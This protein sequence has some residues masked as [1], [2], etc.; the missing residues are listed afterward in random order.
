MADIAL[1]NPAFETSFW[2]MEHVLP[3]IRKR[4]SMPVA[5]LALLGALTPPE[6]RVTILDEN[7]GPLDFERLARAEIVGVTGM[8]VQRRR[9]CE[10]LQELRRR[11]AFVVVGGPWASVCEEEFRDL[12]Q[13]VFV[14]EAEETWPRFLRDWAEG[15]PAR[16][17][18]QAERTDMSAVPVP[19]Y[20]L[21][22]M[23]KYLFGSVQFSRGC[24]H[25]CEFC[26][27][28]VTFGRRPRFKT[29][30]QVLA[31]F[32]ALRAQGMEIIFVVD[33]NLAGNKVAVKEVLQAVARW[34]R[35]RGFPFILVAEASL[36]IADDAAL[37][38]RMA[39]ANIQSVFVGIESLN[40]ASLREARKYTNIRRGA[41][42][43]ER[44][45][46]I[47]DAGIEVWCG[48]MLGFDNDDPT[49]FTAQRDFLREA[50]I[51]DAMASMVY[52]IPRTGS[53]VWVSAQ[54]RHALPPLDDGPGHGPAAATRGQ[55]LLNGRDSAARR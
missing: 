54:V 42:L 40:E 50:R 10:I 29:V 41:R 49:V 1:V 9:M 2:G 18:E 23:K 43:L 33:D 15:R 53:A 6:H 52:A 44:V 39:E 5:G 47:Q 48:M 55:L 36:D 21:L 4:A 22:P 32:E 37:L 28:T 31:E 8:S 3:L 11:G 16:R 13:V 12:A 25:E 35:D 45:R 27:I 51:V 20:D 46:T 7:V 24:P 14:G 19:R 17:Y 30:A 38:E 34:Q 26:D